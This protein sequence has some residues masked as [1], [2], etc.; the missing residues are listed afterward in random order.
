MELRVYYSPTTPNRD[1]TLLVTP[2]VPDPADGADNGQDGGIISGSNQTP[3]RHSNHTCR[4]PHH[5]SK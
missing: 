3:L 1:A 2:S 5:F 4:Q